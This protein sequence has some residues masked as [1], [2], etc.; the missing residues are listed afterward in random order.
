M[1]A[2]GAWV[3]VTLAL[4]DSQYTALLLDL[5]NVAR[6]VGAGIDA[7]D[8]AQDVLL[9]GRVHLD[10]LRDEAKL[11]PWLR[12]MT[13][14]TASRVRDRRRRQHDAVDWQMGPVDPNV[15]LDLAK[16]IAALPVRQ[17][18]ALVLVFAYGYTQEEA[19]E[20]LG[21]HRGTIAASLWHARRRLAK[22]LADYRSGQGGAM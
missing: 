9:H 13:V 15:G 1:E 16:A 4:I 20:M 18:A 7:E 2:K 3:T 17:R 22:E 11:V 8:V 19:A 21:V 12:R 5:A 6:A 10:Q 14:R